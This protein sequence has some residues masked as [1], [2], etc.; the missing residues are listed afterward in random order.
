MSRISRRALMMATT[1]AALASTGEAPARFRNAASLIAVGR[2][3]LAQGPLDAAFHPTGLGDVGAR[4][5]ADFAA[6]RTVV[7]DGWVLSR[8]EAELC[9]R[10]AMLHEESP[11]A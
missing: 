4:I 10:I 8:T 5:R 1:I 9:G 11:A 7:L 2:L 6:G 3:R